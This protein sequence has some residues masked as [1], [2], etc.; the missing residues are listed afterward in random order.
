ML[1]VADL[2]KEV[3]WVTKGDV[4]PVHNQGQCGSSSIF[5]IVDSLISA[6]AIR[7]GKLTSLSYQ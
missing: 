3:N 7:E 4:P 6:L 1:E 5:S 2:P